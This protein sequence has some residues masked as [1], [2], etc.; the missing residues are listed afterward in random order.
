MDN[1]A[2]KMEL[3]VIENRCPV[4]KTTKRAEVKELI[5]QL[6]QTYPDLKER[7]FGAMQRYPL[8]AWEPHGRY[9]TKRAEVKELIYQLSQTY[10]DLKERIFGA[11]QRYPLA[12]WEP[13]GRYKRPKDI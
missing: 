7:I 5:Y 11:M 3:P 8:A 6:S 4:D 1:F 2:Q 13:H 12:A 10:P 9:K